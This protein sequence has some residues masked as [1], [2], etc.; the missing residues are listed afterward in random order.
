MSKKFFCL[1]LILF[2]LLLQGQTMVSADSLNTQQEFFLRDWKFHSGDS[3]QFCTPE[4]ND[5]QW[6]QVSIENFDSWFDGKGWLRTTIVLDSNFNSNGLGFVIRQTGASEIYVDGTLII[7]NGTVGDSEEEEKRFNTQSIP[8]GFNYTPGRAVSIA[9]RYSNHDKE[10]SY[11]SNGKAGSGFE[12]RIVLINKAVVSKLMSSFMINT[13]TILFAAFFMSMGLV[14][15]L[16]FLFYRK[17]RSNLYYF[18]FSFITA[19]YPLGIYVNAF[20]TSFTTSWIFNSIMVFIF[21]L[22]FVSLLSLIFSI[23]H[24]H[25]PKRF[26]WILVSGIFLSVY[27]FLDGPI[28][29]MLMFAFVVYCSCDTLVTI[30]QA[31]R[32]KKKGSR[33][34]GTGVLFF[35]GLIIIGL[36]MVVISAIVQ[37]TINISNGAGAIALMII[38]FLSIISIPVSMSVFLAKDFSATNK[39]LADKLVEV[40][41]LSA[42]AIE[43]EKEKQKILASQN[44]L[45]ESQVKARTSEITEQKKL[46]EEK[47][48]DITDSI[49][50]AKRIQEASLPDPNSLSDL[51]PESFILFKPKDIVSGDFYWFAELKGKKIVVAA[52]CTGHGV[53]GALMSM[54]G[55]NILTKV[56][57]EEGISSPAEILNRLNQE[58]R[59][60]LKQTAS[61]SETRDGMDIAIVCIEADQVEYAGAHRPLWRITNNCCL[62]EIKA[63]K[64]SIG[65][66]QQ[67]EKQFQQHTIPLKKGEMIYL[68]SDGY[69]DQFGG[70]SGKK[71]MTKNLKELL[72]KMNEL[73]MIDQKNKLNTTIE[74]WRCNREQIDDILIIGIRN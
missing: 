37:H 15:F 64:F 66:I 9:V 50:Y 57:I 44:T 59:K 18:L 45:L 34:I 53:P 20:S 56:V 7:Q 11:D 23:F 39:V 28:V 63:N 46:I 65:G 6:K 29:S 60:T 21:P 2:P 38:F 52:D 12:M 22:L 17:N 30:I 61:T 14:H 35:L 3:L 26:K 8:A 31:V 43:Q 54:I 62:E 49:N 41:H 40:E 68:F 70:P 74:E 1:L 55:T 24:D 48:K 71:L 42:L 58:V 25:F 51:F 36:L 19:L 69:A 47:N 4:Y 72:L 27:F 67:E 10:H 13:L 73:S 32:K 33:I 5:S 16:I